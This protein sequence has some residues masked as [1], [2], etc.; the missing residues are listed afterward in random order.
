MALGR[1]GRVHVAWNGSAAATP[2]GPVNAESGRRESSMLSSRLKDDGTGF[3]PERSL[4]THTFGLD[5][6]GTVAADA[7][8]NVYVAWHGKAPGAPAGWQV[9]SFGLRSPM[10]TVRRLQRNGRRGISRPA[11]ADAAEWL[12]SRTRVGLCGA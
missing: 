12:Y 7:D 1:N 8:G 2:M 3:E 11:R 9:A 10:T 4:M 5:G 6:G